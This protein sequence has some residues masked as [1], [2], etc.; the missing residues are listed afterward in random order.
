MVVVHKN[1]FD[2]E[3]HIPEKKPIIV[4]VAFFFIRKKNKKMEF[5]T[6]FL[7]IYIYECRPQIKS[8]I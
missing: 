5:A 7:P 8:P 1:E 2:D 4:V 3:N 6:V